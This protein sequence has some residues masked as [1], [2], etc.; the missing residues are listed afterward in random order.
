MICLGVHINYVNIHNHQSIIQQSFVSGLRV[1]IIVVSKL[2]SFL[3]F[4]PRSLYTKV[5]LIILHNLV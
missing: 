3:I 5:R 2:N 1:S 4:Q